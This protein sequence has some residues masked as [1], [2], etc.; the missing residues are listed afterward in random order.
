[1]GPA[2]PAGRSPSCDY[3]LLF[4]TMFSNSSRGSRPILKDVLEVCCK[5][6]AIAANSASAGLIL[7]NTAA[8]LS[9]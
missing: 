1:M 3:C 2:H 6:H 8:I 5:T 4:R 9:L 7:D